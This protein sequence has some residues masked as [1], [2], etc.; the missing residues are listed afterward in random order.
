M[1]KLFLLFLAFSFLVPNN[2]EAEK[3]SFGSGL[4]WDLNADGVLI[5]SGNGRMPKKQ[6]WSRNQSKI[7]KVII[8]NG[9]ESICE[10]AFKDY[11]NLTSISFPN[12]LY[13][14]GESAFEDC[15]SLTNVI[16]PDSL[17]SISKW[18]FEGCESI[19][20][21]TIPNSVISIGEYAFSDCKNLTSI[22]IP[23]SVISIGQHAFDGCTKLSSLIIPNSVIDIGEW[24]IKDCS[25]LKTISISKNAT[26]IAENAFAQEKLEINRKLKKIIY[27]E[28]VVVNCPDHIL[29]ES[30]THWGLSEK[31]IDSYKN[32]I[33]DAE[34]K[35]IIAKTDGLLI[36]EVKNDLNRIVCYIIEDNGKTG[37]M[38]TQGRW[39]VSYDKGYSKI[40]EFD[41]NYFK[42]INKNSK[43]GI[44]T[45][46]GGE[47]IPISKG[48][49]NIEMLGSGFYKVRDRYYN[50]GILA[51]NGSEVIPVSRGYEDIVF[52]SNNTFSTEK[53]GYSII[54][55]KQGQEISKKKIPFSSSDIKKRGNYTDVRTS[56]HDGK[57]FFI[58][59]KDEYYGLTDSEGRVIVPCEME[60]LESAGSGFLRYKLNGFWGLMNYQGKVLIDT[61]RG[62]T[63]IGDYK[64]FNKRFAYTMN[65]YKGEVDVTGRQISKIRIEEPKQSSYVES[66]SSSSFSSSSSDSNNN[67]N[68][69]NKATTIV[70]E[71]HRDPVPM[72][73]WQQCTNCWGSGK[74][75]CLGACGGTGT[76]YVGNRLHTCISCNG[77]GKKICPYCSGQGGIYVT[78][79][80]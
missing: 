78:V 1:K 39:I 72:Q 4:F 54:C 57:R 79:Y 26:D 21:L 28:G 61:D 77:T 52:N 44:I 70:V 16:L 18:S 7:K 3:K 67:S 46:D 73:E 56:Y 45:H 71:H 6:P 31:A 12:T 37:I 13:S 25:S 8:E 49:E 36:K 68:S 19:I 27:F 59:N 23:N 47:V 51:T 65:G 48:Y 30:P 9:V 80:R 15:K 20:S 41:N 55:N 76:Y 17:L 38:N 14:I 35:L 5:I 22:H 60:A 24:I 10:N 75:M 53:D 33:R 11:H 40:E 62:Y 32:G 42:V 74:V 58:V 29:R 69:E 66:S 43:C 63:S 64:S 2:L 34:G 50:Y